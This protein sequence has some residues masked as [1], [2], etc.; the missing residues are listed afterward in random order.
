MIAKIIT[1]IRV[2]GLFGLYTYKLPESDELSEATILYGDNGVGKSTILRIVF[3][4]LSA[5]NNRSHRT[6]LY[7]ADF[8]KIEVDLVSNITIAAHLL[9]EPVRVLSMEILE[10][11]KK[12]AVWKYTGPSD[13]KNLLPEPEG[14]RI[15]E[16]ILEYSSLMT[17]RPKPTQK[18][19]EASVP[20]G[21]SAYLSALA[22]HVPT[23]FIL[24][25][26]R[27]LDSDTVSDPSDEMEL[28]RVMRYEEPKRINELVVRSREIALSQALNAA[29]KWISRKAVIG[30]NQGSMNVHSVYVDVLRHL[31]KTESNDP[32]LQSENTVNM[33]LQQLETIETKTTAHA[34]YELST[35]LS[36]A[37]FCHA[38][39]TKAK[40]A[41]AK[42][43]RILVAELLKPY[44]KSLERR[45][46]AV[47]PIYQI[48]DQFVTIV[49]GFLSDK[50]IAFSLSQGF[51]IQNRL[52]NSLTPAQ[53]SSGEQ[54]LLLLFCYVL[55]ARDKPSVF[56]ID[57]PEISLNVKWQRQLVQSLLDITAAAEIQFIFASHSMELLAQHRNRVVKLESKI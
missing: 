16:K 30:T 17:K 22:K 29:A 36:T 45:L 33:L 52:G 31:L 32:S 47:E 54:Q 43:K 12:L 14:Y 18:R 51:S 25:A 40:T 24:N 44:I 27:R 11:G 5:A 15:Y 21:E 34:R 23:M 2:Q 46:E 10:D 42:N 26:E 53:L 7:K 6:A 20:Q 48:I 1:A 55:T 9:K 50:S 35:E 19:E 28:R 3:H 38:L 4:L 41:K 37:E 39:T 8:E 49:N 56:M 13:G 57:E